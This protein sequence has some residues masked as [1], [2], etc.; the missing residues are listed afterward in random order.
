MKKSILFAC[1]I[2]LVITAGAQI[3]KG[4]VLL[5]GEI[6][7]T[8]NKAENTARE[9]NSTSLNPAFGVAV[10][11]NTVVGATLIYNSYKDN[12]TISNPEMKG[13]T[14]GGSVFVRRYL[15]IGK[16]F[17]FFGEADVFSEGILSTSELS[18]QKE[19]AK[20]WETGVYLYPGI[21]FAVSKRF[22]IETGFPQLVGFSFSKTKNF[23]NDVLVE[24]DH[25]VGLFAA[26]SAFS[27]ISV[28]F[29]VFLSK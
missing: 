17:F 15:A 16:Q 26:A 11:K 12:F 14:Y 2:A 6:G 7:F 5:G 1:A 22:Q 25:S 27:N 21:S 9:N 29:R 10:Q 8:S 13:H 28:G 18:F 24:T 23:S 3:D 20:S 4:S 19:E